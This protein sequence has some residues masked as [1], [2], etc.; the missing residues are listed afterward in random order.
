MPITVPSGFKILSIKKMRTEEN[1][2]NKVMCKFSLIMLIY[3]VLQMHFEHPDKTALNRL[4]E[5]HLY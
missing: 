3:K 5:E 2:F 1:Y 4:S